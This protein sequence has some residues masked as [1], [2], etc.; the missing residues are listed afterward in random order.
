MCARGV[1]RRERGVRWARWRECGSAGGLKAAA[2]ARGH[3]SGSGACRFKRSQAPSPPIV[4]RPLVRNAADQSATAPSAS[5]ARPA[6]TRTRT[7]CTPGKL[8]T[9][10][11]F[12]PLPCERRIKHFYGHIG[13][14]AAGPR[15]A[16]SR[17]GPWQ[18]RAQPHAK[19]VALLQRAQLRPR[20]AGIARWKER[21]RH[22][23]HPPAAAQVG[24]SMLGVP[25][26][27]WPLVRLLLHVLWHNL[28]V[29]PLLRVAANSTARS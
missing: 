28:A 2:R 27:R 19:P 7:A 26:A 1:E 14:P 9:A 17:R 5:S 16:S 10:G 29:R 15:P 8:R 11:V 4:R 20:R 13:P 18:P 23:R 3:Q 12:G 25:R 21:Q 24:G 22:C 6:P